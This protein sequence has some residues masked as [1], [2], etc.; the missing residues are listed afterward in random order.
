MPLSRRMLTA[1]LLPAVVVGGLL[2]GATSASAN[3]AVTQ[4]STDPFTDAQAQHRTEVEPDTFAFGSTIVSAFQVGRVSGGGSSDVGFAT[5]TDGGATWTQGFLPGTTANTGGPCGQISDAAVAF[6]AKHNVWLISSLGVNCPTGE[7][8]LTSRSTDGGKTFGN[9]V[10]TATGSL[11]KNWIVCDNTATSP[12]F[13]SC[14]TEY[15][16]TSSGDSLRMKTSTDGG[17]TWGPARAPSGTHTGLGG[18]PVVQPNGT[19]VVPY[20]SLNDQIRSFRSTNG[21]ASWTSTTQVASISHHDAAGGLREEALPS[22]EIDSTGTVYVAWSDCRFRSGCP[23]NDIVLSKSANGTTWS[24]PTRIPIDATTS[25]V[26][27]FVPGIGVDPSTA[28]SSARIGLT[29][30]F[31]PNA[32]CTA[33]TCQLDVG[34]ISS[35]NGG[36]S[37]GTATQVAGP[38]SLSWIPNTSQGRMFGDYISTSVRPGGNAFPVVPIAA[39]PSGSSFTMGMFTPTGGLPITGGARRAVETP[40]RQTAATNSVLTAF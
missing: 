37:W 8:V 1:A 6:D 15:D 2:V 38:M 26:D 36:T 21:G 10:T 23:G 13:G 32:S 29:Y 27:H 16:I 3:V 39:P 14:Y 22:A 7:P 28:G 24:S 11:D 34:F 4:V 5:S 19:V 20:L 31:Y 25:T 35:T 18:Q 33:A 9:P 17:L 40:T 30:Y 12:F